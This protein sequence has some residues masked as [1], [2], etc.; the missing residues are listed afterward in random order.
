MTPTTRSILSVL[1]EKG[2]L[3]IKKIEGNFLGSKKEQ[4]FEELKNLKIDGV[5]SYSTDN[6]I[7]LKNNKHI[8]ETY[9]I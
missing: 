4:I 7:I 2:L 3:R 1:K 8:I 6:E 9:L 5:T